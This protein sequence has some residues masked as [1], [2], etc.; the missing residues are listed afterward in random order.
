[1]SAAQ[2]RIGEGQFTVC[3]PEWPNTRQY[4]F[5]PTCQPALGQTLPFVNGL[6][7]GSAVQEYPHDSSPIRSLFLMD[8]PQ[9]SAR[10][11]ERHC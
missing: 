11:L 2:T 9:Q 6:P 7:D 4:N 1:M 3:P 5:S 10:S 8:I